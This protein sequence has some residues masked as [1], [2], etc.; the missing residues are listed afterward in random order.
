M[1]PTTPFP[2]TRR[3]TPP[4][5]SV[6]VML[7]NITQVILESIRAIKCFTSW[8][9]EDLT[10]TN[11]T[12]KRLTIMN[13]CVITMHMICVRARKTPPITSVYHGVLLIL[14]ATANCLARV[15]SANKQ[16]VNEI[17]VALAFA[18]VSDRARSLTFVWNTVTRMV[19][20][21]VY[22]K[23]V[24]MIQTAYV[25]ANALTPALQSCNVMV[26]AILPRMDS[27]SIAVWST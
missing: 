26:S 12:S 11:T 4:L 9:K 24:I 6:I 13:N 2:I 1:M 21:T 8:S 23:N 17:L 20:E 14:M 25:C 3:M 18:S 10:F 19:M 5:H 7:M 22:S 27:V 15:L 16:I